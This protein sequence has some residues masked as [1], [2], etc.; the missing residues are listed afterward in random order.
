[1]SGDVGI[2]DSQDEQAEAQALAK[3]R[4]EIAAGQSVSHAVVV[5][6]LETWG[7]ESELPCPRPPAV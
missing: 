5:K 1:M 7:T 3:A 2:F 6:W 4:A